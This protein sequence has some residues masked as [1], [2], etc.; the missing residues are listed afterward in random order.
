MGKFSKKTK[1]IKKLLFIFVDGVGIGKKDEKINPFFSKKYNFFSRFFDEFP[2]IKN[3]RINKEFISVFPINA[4]MGVK[5]LP[6]SGTG[7]T[8]I[9]CGINAQKILGEHFGP[10]PHSKLRPFIEEKNLLIELIKNNLKVTF[11]NAYPKEFFEYIKSG[12]KKLSVTTLSCQYANIRLKDI[13][14]LISEEAISAEITNKYWIEKFNYE[15]NYQNPHKAGEILFNICKKNNLTMFEYFLT[16]HAGHSMSFSF[17][18]EVLTNLDGLLE[19][20]YEKLIKSNENINILIVSD[21]G[22]I[23]DLSKKTHTLNP[24]L[25]LA[26]GKENLFFANNIKSLK[27]IKNSILK[28]FEIP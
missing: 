26:I 15:L 3:A 17:A 24:A 13:N 2:S 11:V 22:N 21:H 5:G 1:N 4:K 19:G 8:S 28:Y 12:R 14:D 20:F 6:Q 23:E 27:D 25:G 9:F 7:Q 10:Y 18:E 16:D